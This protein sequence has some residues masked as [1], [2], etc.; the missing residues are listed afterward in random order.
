MDILHFVY[1]DIEP[2]SP[3]DT[4]DKAI[5]CFKNHSCTHIVV[6]DGDKLLGLLSELDLELF[7]TQATVK[8]YAY[9]F[10]PFHVGLDM[11]WLEVLD[12]FAK[13]E[14]NIMPVLDADQKYVGYYELTHVMT[15]FGETPF[16]TEPGAIIIIE[17]A[18]KDYSFSEVAQIVETENGKILGALVSQMP[19][20][21]VQITIKF[22]ALVYNDIM[23]SLRRYGYHI[24]SGV[25]DDQFIQSLKE[26]SDYLKKYL[27]L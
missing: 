20:D 2:L 4:M 16:F 10:Q 9:L 14:S 27:D 21:K 7:D 15:S 11:N 22:S 5:A 25:K 8:D 23:Q 18:I 12:A 1:D 19:E 3:T 17:K 26:R 13:N 24:V 6:T